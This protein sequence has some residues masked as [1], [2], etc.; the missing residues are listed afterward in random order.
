MACSMTLLAALLLLLPLQCVAKN[1]TSAQLD[2]KPSC[3]PSKDVA[4]IVNPMASRVCKLCKCKQCT[5]CA[6]VAPSDIGIV[7]QHS[8]AAGGSS[9]KAIKNAIKKPKKP[10]PKGKKYGDRKRRDQPADESPKKAKLKKSKAKRKRAVIGRVIGI[11]NATL[12]GNALL[13]TTGDAA[14]GA[15]GDGLPSA[16]RRA[17]A[18]DRL[19]EAIGSTLVLVSLVGLAALV[20]F[21][22]VILCCGPAPRPRLTVVDS[23]LVMPADAELP[24]PIK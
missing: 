20:C 4:G 11:G 2:C 18:R 24:S 22:V 15:A 12:V 21:R 17:P 14:S 3:K 13:A 6:T 19:S 1:C 10:A 8:T 9:R 5:H 7:L 16:T 23:P